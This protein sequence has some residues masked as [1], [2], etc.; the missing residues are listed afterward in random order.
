[1]SAFDTLAIWLNLD[2]QFQEALGF[3]NRCLDIEATNLSCLVQKAHASLF[4]GQVQEARDIA[5][6]A[7]TLGTVT[8][9]DAKAK[10][11]F[12]EL[13]DQTSGAV[14]CTP[15]TRYPHR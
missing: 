5:E 3:A 15:L 13:L 1:M 9:D 6:R 2:G 4:L 12:T 10:Q 8:E 7:L 11:W 14:S